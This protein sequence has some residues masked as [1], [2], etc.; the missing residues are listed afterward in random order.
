[1][2]K[3][4]RYNK[5]TQPFLSY[6]NPK[7]YLE[8]SADFTLPTEPLILVKHLTQFALFVEVLVRDVFSCT[9]PE[10]ENAL[11]LA[12]MRADR[13]GI[14]LAP[15]FE[16]SWNWFLEIDGMRGDFTG[17][18]ANARL[19]SWAQCCILF[20]LTIYSG[21]KESDSVLHKRIRGKASEFCYCGMLLSK[22]SNVVITDSV[23]N[24]FSL[25]EMWM[26]MR[27]IIPT[28]YQ[29]PYDVDMKDY[30]YALFFRYASFLTMPQKGLDKLMDNPKF[31]RKF[32]PTE[33]DDEED[34]GDEEEEAFDEY[35]KQEIPIGE[36]YF[37]TSEYFYEGELLFVSQMRRFFLSTELTK[38]SDEYR[39]IFREPPT[40]NRLV[41]VRQSLEKMVRE[42]SVDG[43]LRQSVNEEF[44]K[45][46]LSLY[47]YHGEAERFKRMYPNMNTR[48]SEILAQARPADLKH[49][50]EV[51]TSTITDL[52][53][54][55]GMEKEMVLAT[56]IVTRDFLRHDGN[57]KA[58]AIDKSFVLEELVSL[59]QLETLID[60]ALVR[61]KSPVRSPPLLVKLMSTYYVIHEGFLNKS[62][63]FG[64]N[65]LIWLAILVHRLEWIRPNKIHP[66]IC[67]FIKYFVPLD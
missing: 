3:R 22:D 9:D 59:D 49:A 51:I 37:L 2:T 31:Y 44:K 24:K 41:V 29:N 46:C 48:A 64:E 14:D 33:G 32:M 18:L 20:H 53:K 26:S 34:S 47:L 4:I 65:Y 35:K 12:I 25:D 38:C 52:I 54:K 23:I 6:Q 15:I 1:M 56:K 10:E 55:P 11:T 42:V 63:D 5:K 28:L 62:L 50:T 7:Q 40:K 21:D 66:S 16:L 19:L 57:K 60:L 17:R 61:K 8:E 36:G 58:D 39:F 45:H 27:L 30:F 43:Q 67:E 13:L